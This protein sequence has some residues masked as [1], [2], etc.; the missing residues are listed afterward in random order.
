MNT[1]NQAAE[2]AEAAKKNVPIV[3]L[4]RNTPA[5]EPPKAKELEGKI[6]TLMDIINNQE[7]S[8]KPSEFIEYPSKKKLA[9][10]EVLPPE[11][12]EQILRLKGTFSFQLH[13]SKKYIVITTYNASEKEYNFMIVNLSN[14]YVYEADTIKLAKRKV[15]EMLAE[16]GYTEELAEEATEKAVDEAA[17]ENK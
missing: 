4:E 15:L 1:I 8:R 5:K 10:A 11:Q 16:E 7:T 13:K 2:Q 14:M 12:L 9:E 6:L 17:D 3:R